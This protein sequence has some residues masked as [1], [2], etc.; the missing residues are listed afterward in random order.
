MKRL[1]LGPKREVRS[2]VF[3]SAR[4][5]G[6]APR[7]DDV[8]IA[9]YSKCG[10]TWMQRIV[11]MLVFGTAEPKPIWDL[12]PWPDM[13]LFGPIEET[14]A[15]AE[16]Q[17]HR[18]F[19]KSHLPYDALPIYEGVKF[20][21]VARDGRDAALSLHNHLR[22]FRPE[23]LAHLTAISLDD[24]KF[25]TPYPLVSKDPAEFF[26]AWVEDSVYDGQG[27]AGASF[28]E[29][30]NSFWAAKDN[31][32]VLLVHYADLKRDRDGEMRR[33]AAFL[34]IDVAESDWPTMIEAAG[35]ETMKRQGEVL[36]PAAQRLWAEGSNAF[37]NRGLN[38][39]WQDVV[40]PGDLALYDAKVKAQFA[41]D[42]ADW[43][44][45]GRHG[46]E[47]GATASS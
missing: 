44:E 18:R 8:I 17:T 27:D 26:H 40:S 30:E 5:Q 41:P 47:L 32:D 25:G 28:F 7:R 23:T 1:D 19:F 12:S 4:W 37:F 21:H 36:I 2:R 3:D 45:H 6:Y 46:A 24:P 16:A 13:R 35:F 22:N 10:T 38:G 43:I 14:L 42:L 33:V 29:V 15:N 39:Q 31:P 34:D 20:I 9:T 11:S